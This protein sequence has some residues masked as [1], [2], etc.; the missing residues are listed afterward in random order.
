MSLLEK[1]FPAP[2]QAK[3]RAQHRSEPSTGQSPA[4][5]RALDLENLFDAIQSASFLLHFKRE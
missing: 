4:Q 2:N 3:V 1:N 5:V